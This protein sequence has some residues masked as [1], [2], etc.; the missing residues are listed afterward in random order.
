MNARTQAET[1]FRQTGVVYLC[2]TENEAAK[3]EPWL[4]HAKAYQ[5]DSRLIGPTRPTGCCQGRR[6]ARPAALYTPSDGCAEPEKAT[7]C[8]RQCRFSK[9]RRDPRGLAP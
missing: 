5:I 2:E 4:A 7:V 3:Y 9:G 6:G 1:G 8:Y